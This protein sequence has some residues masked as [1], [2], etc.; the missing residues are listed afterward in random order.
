MRIIEVYRDYFW[1]F[2]DEQKDSVKEKIDYVLNIVITVQ[3]VP[4]KFFKHLDDGIYEIRVKVASDIFRIFC[5]FDEGKLVILLNGF[6]KKSQKTPKNELD[7]AK[8]IRKEY[9]EDKLSKN[10]R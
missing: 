7:K 5:F 3:R 2:Y 10:N 4:E 6:Q 9:Y 8:R 1:E